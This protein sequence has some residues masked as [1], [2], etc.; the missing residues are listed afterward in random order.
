MTCK[1]YV[2]CLSD[3]SRKCQKRCDYCTAR[4]E[5]SSDLKKCSACKQQFYC[6]VVSASITLNIF[7]LD[8]QKCQKLAWTNGEHKSECKDFKTRGVPGETA[9]LF[10]RLLR[11]LERENGDSDTC[12]VAEGDDVDVTALESIY[13]KLSTIE[14]T[15]MG[16]FLA[17]LQ[18][19][20][21]LSVP[22]CVKSARKL[23]NLCAQL[24]NNQF[25][26]CDDIQDST[27][28]SALYLNASMINHSCRP[29]AFPTFDGIILHV[30]CL[31]KI[32][33]GQGT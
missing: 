28:G 20:R 32:R 1:P 6:Q 26:I 13:E 25:A 33:K 7:Y 27:V 11:R 30:K 21:T 14:Q 23:L 8:L 4:V 5:K 24:K 12:S 9:V 10:S 31:T 2:H 15:E 16:M 17:R 19:T 3:K 22:K 18:A 29:N